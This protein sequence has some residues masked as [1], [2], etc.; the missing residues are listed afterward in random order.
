MDPETVKRWTPVIRDTLFVLIAAFMFVYG[1]IYVH[2]PGRLTLILG[3]GLAL[4]GAPP[5]FRVRDWVRNGNDDDTSKED[6][7]SHLP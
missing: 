5:V 6:R 4:L 7:W 2:E 3:A 1:T